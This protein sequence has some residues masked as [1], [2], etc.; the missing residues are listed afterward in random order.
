MKLSP[1]TGKNDVKIKNEIFK[2]VFLLACKRRK[3]CIVFYSLRRLGEPSVFFSSPIIA[4]QKKE[5]EGGGEREKDFT[6]LATVV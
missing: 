6:Q 4:R 1:P 5:V 2:I 3:K